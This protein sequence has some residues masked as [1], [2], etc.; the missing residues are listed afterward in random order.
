[1]LVVY[2]TLC[3]VLLYTLW[4]LQG[5]IVNSPETI[6]V[7]DLKINN[8]VSKR[9]C[10]NEIHKCIGYSD[11]V[12]I[13]EG[14][15]TCNLSK[16]ICEPFVYT[17][18]AETSEEKCDPTHGSYFALNVNQ[19]IG[20]VW[21]CVRTLSN[22]FNREE[23]LHNHVCNNGTLD[24]NVNLK[25]PSIKDCSC[26]AGKILM[27]RDGDTKTPRCVDSKLIPFLPSFKAV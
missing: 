5:I 3:V 13:C 16:N 4:I 8:G 20:S 17:V 24:V 11:C 2:A 25:T 15:F 26:P 19:I 21:F 18:A 12:D 14:N 1:M 6:R 27:V 23:E 7:E 9:D 22:L 10:K